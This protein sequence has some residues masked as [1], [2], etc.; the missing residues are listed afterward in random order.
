MTIKKIYEYA[1]KLGVLTFSTISEGEVHSRIAHFNGYDEEGIYFRTMNT[2]PYYR[3][4]MKTGRLTV[5]GSS[6]SK[7]DHDENG[8]PLFKPGYTFRLIGEVRKV[9][10]EELKEKAINN[11]V[12]EMAVKDAERYPAMAEGNFIIN[13]AKVEIYD[14]D[15]ECE[16]RDHKLLRT[17]TAFGGVTYNQ[18]GPR[19]TNKCISCG[20]CK[21][22]CTFK[23][24]K[25]GNPYEVIPERCDDCGSCRIACPVEA[26]EES[27][28]F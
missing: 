22:V 21:R 23:A 25:E 2:K 13:K 18:V 6:E 16:T 9:S 12:L 5:C 4:L 20:K 19:I 14:Y 24:I 1:E 28:T 3:Q 7:I 17:R 8:M 11:K 15:F 26:I 10:L 27:L